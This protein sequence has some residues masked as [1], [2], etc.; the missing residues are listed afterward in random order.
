[1]AKRTTRQRLRHDC[2][3]VGFAISPKITLWKQV[4]T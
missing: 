2:Y 4:C 1:M 3:A